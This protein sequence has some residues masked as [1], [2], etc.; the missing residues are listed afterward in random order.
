M[1]TKLLMALVIT[2]ALALIV[3]VSY[4]AGT[5]AGTNREYVRVVNAVADAYGCD[6]SEVEMDAGLVDSYGHKLPP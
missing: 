2:V 6:P 3:M 1:K 4:T 5:R